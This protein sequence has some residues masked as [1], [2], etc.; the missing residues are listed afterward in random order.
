[1][2]DMLA[3]YLG[4]D[5]DGALYFGGHRPVS[6]TYGLRASGRYVQIHNPEAYVV[7][8]LESGRA[9]DPDRDIFIMERR[10]VSG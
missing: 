8:V 1:M 10:E 7:A 2:D 6:G 3:S 4:A 9:P 5:E